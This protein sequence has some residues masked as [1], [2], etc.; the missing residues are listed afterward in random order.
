MR[1]H[2]PINKPILTYS[3]HHTWAWW[4]WSPQAKNLTCGGGTGPPDRDLI[5]FRYRQLVPP[6][7]CSRPRM[8]TTNLLHTWTYL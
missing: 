8:V 5:A 2:E 7:S 4:D 6:K 1:I 3:Y